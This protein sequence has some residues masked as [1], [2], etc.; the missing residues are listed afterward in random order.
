MMKSLIYKNICWQK[1]W[2]K[3]YI[4]FHKLGFVETLENRIMQKEEW[5]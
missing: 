3:Q 5:E 1:I 4:L 2:Q